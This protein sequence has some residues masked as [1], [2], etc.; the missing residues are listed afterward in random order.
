MKKPKLLGFALQCSLPRLLAHLEIVFSS[1]LNAIAPR[2]NGKTLVKY[3]L[4][5][6]KKSVHTLV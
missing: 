6:I 3:P 5:G 4:Y 2:Q 1:I